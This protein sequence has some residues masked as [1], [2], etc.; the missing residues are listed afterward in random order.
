MGREQGADRSS[1]VFQAMVIFLLTVD[2]GVPLNGAAL[3]FNWD[4]A[5]KL[6]TTTSTTDR[7][8]I[9]VDVALV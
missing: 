4:K 5:S 1:D 8:G 2:F 7:R 3:S 9:T 6:A